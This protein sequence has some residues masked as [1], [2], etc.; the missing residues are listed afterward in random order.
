M[1]GGTKIG[2]A[3]FDGSWGKL[4]KTEFVRVYGE[5]PQAVATGVTAEEAW[6]V[7]NGKKTTKKETSKD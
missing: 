4:K 1:A 7:F 6:L 5:T 3:W 2:N